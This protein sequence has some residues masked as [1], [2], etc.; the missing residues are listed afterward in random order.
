[1]R[2]LTEKEINALNNG[3]KMMFESLVSELY[4]EIDNDSIALYYDGKNQVYNLYVYTKV[5][6]FDCQMNYT[7]RKLD[8]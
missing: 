5:Y 8:K 2:K 3:D 4:P 7:T 6:T 1:M